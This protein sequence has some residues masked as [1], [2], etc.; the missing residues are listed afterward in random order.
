MSSCGGETQTKVEG[1]W[2]AFEVWQIIRWEDVASKNPNANLTSSCSMVY[3]QLFVFFP[4]Y[5]ILLFIFGF[6]KE[7]D[8]LLVCVYLLIIY[9]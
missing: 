1:I 6:L 2:E 3:V 7:P 9:H 8:L 4:L 5:Y